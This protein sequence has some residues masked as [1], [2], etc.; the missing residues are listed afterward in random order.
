MIVTRKQIR[1]LRSRLAAGGTALLIAFASGAAE[2]KPGTP[3]STSLTASLFPDQVVAKGKWFEIKQSEVDDMFITFKANRAALGQRVPEADRSRIEADILDKLIATQL[4]LRR[5]TDADREK[6]KS[7]SEEL[8]G[9]QMKQAPSEESFNR[10]LV[11]VGMTPEKYRAQ[12]A[13]QA[14]VKSVID[15]EIK[16]QQTISEADIKKFY[17]ENPRYFQ[18][19][20]LAR[21][22]HILISIHNPE[23]AAELAPNKKAEKKALAESLL[24]RAR[25]GEN[26]ADLVKQF[27]EDKASKEKAGEYVIARVKEDRS[28][29]VVP[30]FEAA[31]FS[32][33]PG[34]ISDVVATRYGYHIIKLLEKIP[35]QKVE[36]AKVEAKIKE[37]LSQEAVQKALPERIEQLKKEAGVE[38]LL[39]PASE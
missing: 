14:I 25:K 3:A 32:L 23:T 30:E 34:Q 19:P 31:A 9:E 21:V 29:A 28:R 7:L 24:A 36:L 2:T 27:S 33:L 22:S 35:P 18:E 11:A 10:Q 16:V 13:E 39:K 26:F 17:D 38:I 12:I 6:A 15:R 1:L 20:E 5:A 8:I 37:T 4:F